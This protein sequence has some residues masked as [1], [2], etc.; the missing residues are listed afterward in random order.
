MIHMKVCGSR[1]SASLIIASTFI[2]IVDGFAQNE[3]KTLRKLP[4][5][6]RFE[7]AKMGKTPRE[8]ITYTN[9]KGEVVQP[10]VLYDPLYAADYYVDSANSFVKLVVRPATEDDREWLRKFIDYFE[11]RNSVLHPLKSSCDS[12]LIIL[13]SFYSADQL[14]PRNDSK[15][16]S[17]QC[18]VLGLIEFCGIDKLYVEND[19]LQSAYFLAVQHGSRKVREKYFNIL[20][21]YLHSG[22]AAMMEDRILLEN[23]YRQKYGT[24]VYY[25]EVKN[26]YDLRPIADFNTVDERRKAVGLPPLKDYVKDW[27]INLAWYQF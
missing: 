9:L 17:K 20:K 3:L 16:K 1:M 26:R 5:V 12:A 11:E 23:G 19:T 25:N 10:D 24:Q 22:D 7:M 15:Y 4:S 8:D 13:K 21:P 27:N 2:G 18:K 6:E 14:Y